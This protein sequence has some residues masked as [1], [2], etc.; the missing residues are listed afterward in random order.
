MKHN[1]LVRDKIPEIIKSNGETPITHI[2]SDKE[3]FQKL[4][5][6]LQEEINEFIQSNEKEEL[7][8]ILEVISAICDYKNINQE[9]L[10]L[11]RKTKTQEKGQF[12]NKIILD[13]T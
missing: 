8:D 13:K 5:E 6:K 3:Y 2:A 7:A 10:E 1:K 4:K 9:E 11:I 12:K